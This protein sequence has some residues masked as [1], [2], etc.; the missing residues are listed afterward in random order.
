MKTT[1]AVKTPLWMRA[2]AWLAA[3]LLVSVSGCTELVGPITE[4]A[5]LSSGVEDEQRRVLFSLTSEDAASLSM[6]A[7]TLEEGVQG[8]RWCTN[9]LGWF[10]PSA[11]A[12]N[13][14]SEK[15]PFG[16]VTVVE[17]GLRLAAGVRRAAPFVWT[18]SPGRLNPFPEEGDFDLDVVLTAEKPGDY[19]T[20]LWALMWNPAETVGK[21]SPFQAPV[22]RIWTD[23]HNGL[24]VYLFDRTAKVAGNATAPHSYRLSYRDGAYMLYVDGEPV[25][26]PVVTPKRPNAIWLGHPLFADF[27]AGDW[28]DFLVSEITVSQPEPQLI[29]V[30]VDV[31]PAGCPNPFNL[32]SRGVLPVAVL[33]VDPE[34]LE[35]SQIDP[36]SIQLAGVPALRWAWEDVATPAAPDADCSDAGPDGFLDLTLKFESAAVAA[37]ILEAVGEAAEGDVVTLELTGALYEDF[38]STPIAGEDV[39]VIRGGGDDHG[40]TDDDEEDEKDEKDKGKGNG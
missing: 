19:G 20:G 35:L 25:L 1:T 17:G 3:L 16:D 26:G 14:R 10:D 13:R 11:Q 9:G 2:S 4:A 29:A 5:P 38:G 21:N 24:N 6:A 7:G 27:G 8:P 31:K 34:E 32:K 36:T 40:K 18:G 28:S 23:R 15:P 39:V 22:L 37:A 30:P 33:G 12:C